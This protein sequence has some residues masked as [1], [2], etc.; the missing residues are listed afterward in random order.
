VLWRLSSYRE[1]LL[2]STTCMDPDDSGNGT[3]TPSSDAVCGQS[4]AACFAAAR[5]LAA[6]QLRDRAALECNTTWSASAAAQFVPGGRSRRMVACVVTREAGCQGW[7]C[8]L[9]KTDD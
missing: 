8:A 3:E 9:R 5:H 7:G 2:G 1:Q 4:R 6:L